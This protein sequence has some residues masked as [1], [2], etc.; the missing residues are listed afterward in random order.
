MIE[1]IGF[2][3]LRRVEEEAGWQDR[4]NPSRLLPRGPQP[5]GTFSAAPVERQQLAE[6]V[7]V[8]NVSGPPVGTGDGSIKSGVRVGE[9]LRASV[10]VVGGV[11]PDASGRD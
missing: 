11:L 2:C 8:G 4:Q 7:V 1:L 9:P 3:A 6:G 5:K 10:V